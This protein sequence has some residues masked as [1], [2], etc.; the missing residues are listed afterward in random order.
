MQNQNSVICDAD[1]FHENNTGFDNL[2]RIKNER[3]DFKITLFAIPGLCSTLFIDS[4]KKFDWIELCPHGWMHPSPRECESWTYDE[5]IDYLKKI[6]PLGW[7]KIFK[8]PGWQISDGMYKALLEF[9]Y[10]VADQKYND[11]RRPKELKIFYPPLHHYHIGHMGGHNRN[12]I[13]GFVNTIIQEEKTF[14]FYDRF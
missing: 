8:A 2:F 1:D 4:V 6:E 3:K 14:S 11:F 12:E 10:A 13:G 7:R 9:G 5:S